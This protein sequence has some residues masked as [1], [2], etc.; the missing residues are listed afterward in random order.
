[1]F[2]CL[3]WP[4]SGQTTLCFCCSIVVFY[5]NFGTTFTK[6]KQDRYGVSKHYLQIAWSEGHSIWHDDVSWP[7]DQMSIT[8]CSF[9]LLWCNN[10]FTRQTGNWVFEI[11]LFL[12]T[13]TLCRLRYIALSQI[14]WLRYVSFRLRF[15]FIVR[16]SLHQYAN[17][18]TL[19][20]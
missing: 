8:L 1:M 13:T 4:P 11:C 2:A 14:M 9:S 15:H 18:A 3:S 7:P 17:D 5:F 20:K 10:D 6:W 16:M 12:F 19:C